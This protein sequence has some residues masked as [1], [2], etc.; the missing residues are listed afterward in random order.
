MDWKEGSGGDGV[1]GTLV[2][3]RERGISGL[4]RGMASI[5]RSSYVGVTSIGKSIVCA[6]GGNGGRSGAFMLNMPR[7]AL[8]ISS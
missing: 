7:I 5:K 3:L 4:S 2:G 6:C 1:A 8:I